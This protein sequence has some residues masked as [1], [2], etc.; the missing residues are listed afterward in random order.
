MRT[1]YLPLKAEYFDSIKAGVKT[2]EY[3]RCTMYWKKRL[4]GRQYD[5]IV[6]TKGYPSKTAHERRLRLPW[7]G[8]TVKT[9]Q[10]PHFGP[11]IVEVYAID[12]RSVPS[13]TIDLK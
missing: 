11:T 10:H 7:R 3:R 9:I 4:E 12:V 5:E 1:L 13:T 8:C 6:L 2:E